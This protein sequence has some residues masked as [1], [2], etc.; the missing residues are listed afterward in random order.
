MRIWAV[1]ISSVVLASCSEPVVTT[2]SPTVAGSACDRFRQMDRA[3]FETATR[4]NWVI[5]S[6]CWIELNSSYRNLKPPRALAE[7][8]PRVIHDLGSRVGYA[9]TAAVGAY[10]CE[11]ATVYMIKGRDWNMLGPQSILVHELVH[12]AQCSTQKVRFIG[13]E[14]EREAYVLQAKFLRFA[15]NNPRNRYTDEQKAQILG[16][17]DRVEKDAETACKVLRGLR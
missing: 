8:E 5:L 9:P 12:H 15:V 11:N 13:C 6:L 14:E 16:D 2:F 17:A 3:L 1:A 7:V 4:E 10:N